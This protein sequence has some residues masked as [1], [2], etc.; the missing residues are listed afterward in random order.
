MWSAAEDDVKGCHAYGSA[1]D[2]VWPHSAYGRRRDQLSRNVE[3][4][5]IIIRLQLMRSATPV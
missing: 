3:R 1:S 4:D 5:E 2:C